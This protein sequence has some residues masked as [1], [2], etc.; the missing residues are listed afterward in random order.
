MKNIWHNFKKY[1]LKQPV[2]LVVVLLM[3]LLL[4]KIAF[5]GVIGD[6]VLEVVGWLAQ[7]I[8]SV[9]G[10]LV[11]LV[12]DVMITVA[13]Y[14]GF[15]SAAPVTQG[16]IIIRDLC[17]MFFILILLIACFGTILHLNS[18]N[19]N[20]LLKKILLAAV[21]INFSKMICGLAIDAAQVVML[22]F[23]AGFSGIGAGNFS[24]L[25]GINELLQMRT[26]DIDANQT[27]MSFM[28]MIGSFI[29]AII[30]ALVALVVMISILATLCIRIA[31]LWIWI[32]LSPFAYFFTILPSQ[33]GLART[34]WSNF[35]SNLISGP[36]LAFFI[37]LS[38]ATLGSFSTDSAT[39]NSQMGFETGAIQSQAQGL[40]SPSIGITQAGTADHLLRMAMSLA[41][42]IGG[43][44]VTKKAGGAAGA[45]AGWG[46]NKIKKGYAWGKKQARRPLDLAK[47][48]TKEAASAVYQ[49]GKA[50]AFG[51]AKAGDVAFGR[52]MSGDQNH[53]GY[54]SKAAVGFK[55]LAKGEPIKAGVKAVSRA[56]G[57][58]L[59]AKVN[60]ARYEATTKGK[61]T[62]AYGREYKEA[63]A[64]ADGKAYFKQ[65]D[66]AGKVF[67]QSKDGVN[68][69]A[70]L[71]GDGK[72]KY[73]N[74]HDN[75]EAKLGR[76]A[77]T[78][79]GRNEQNLYEGKHSSKVFSARQEAKYSEEEKNLS[80][81]KSEFGGLSKEE[82][83]GRLRT[84]ADPE[85]RKALYWAAIEKGSVPE[86][87]I[88]LH[89]KMQEEFASSPNVWKKIVE[90]KE[91]KQAWLGMDLNNPAD[92]ETLK[93]RIAKGKQPL[94]K[95]D[96]SAMSDEDASKLF[97]IYNEVLPA[98]KMQSALSKFDSIENKKGFDKIAKA[99]E[100]LADTLHQNKF[101]ETYQNATT[102]GLTGQDAIYK[103]LEDALSD[104]KITNLR[105]TLAG[106][107]GNLEKAFGYKY[108]YSDPATGETKEDD[109]LDY[110]RMKDFL[111]KATGK[112]IT[113]MDPDQL[114]KYE[115]AV[116]NSM[117][118]EKFK[119]IDRSDQSGEIS[120]I[121]A[122]IS[123]KYNIP[124]SDRIAQYYPDLRGDEDAAKQNEFISKAVKKLEVLN[125]TQ[126]DTKEVKEFSRD[127]A[128]HNDFRQYLNE[129]IENSGDEQAQKAAYKEFFETTGKGDKKLSDNASKNMVEELKKFISRKIASNN[130]Y[131]QQTDF[132]T[133][134]N[135]NNNNF[136]PT[137]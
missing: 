102:N 75:S 26:G 95:Q 23:V 49:G 127:I 91:S 13:Q 112:Q 97:G 67:Y 103:G 136:R 12:V 132:R 61:Y 125:P 56:A 70:N 14:N 17:N 101:R 4:P 50:Q 86:D 10:Q 29:L 65:K 84:T 107:T 63:V 28:T 117:T 27:N 16:W 134:G 115:N 77:L 114:R 36:I 87:D 71:G 25:L 46:F 79:M 33:S 88:N 37:W 123:V 110:D 82:T 64:D 51:L 128:V 42:L 89:A 22:T 15:I 121:A 66:A 2:L 9:V 76:V 3:V 20:S 45:G 32:I 122:E 73:V 105:N 108:K 104:R 74:E 39:F 113:D 57:F 83:L 109:K 78:K 98:G 72:I 44:M 119:A 35:T 99:I 80:K 40:T 62:D 34:W 7:I 85:R 41:F 81:L 90:E 48:K 60:R 18:Y 19:L 124:G 100:K 120:R 8:L 68:Y 133:A 131:N 111:R 6:F 43:L 38:V 116:A 69:D 58:E 129:K 21:L 94:E 96:L 135:R 47:R 30:Y 126:F 55:S 92:V 5:A 31:F 53:P 118:F 11:I 137:V 130:A 106:F 59:D 54:V 1:F 52:A 93:E 24:S